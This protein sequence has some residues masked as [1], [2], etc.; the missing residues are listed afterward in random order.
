MTTDLIARIE[1]LEASLRMADEQLFAQEQVLAWLLAQHPP[2][3]ALNFLQTQAN[4]LDG[5][6]K[7]AEC[8]VLLDSLSESVQEL[9]GIRAAVEGRPR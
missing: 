1:Q 5:H 3:V 6:P 2:Q 4:E 9:H 7:F 8:V